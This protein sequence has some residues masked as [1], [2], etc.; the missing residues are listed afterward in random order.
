MVSHVREYSPLTKLL[1]LT[2]PPIHGPTRAA[3]M[4]PQPLDRAQETTKAYAQAVLE[5]GETESVPVLDVFAAVERAL[6]G[7][8]EQAAGLFRDGLHLNRDGYQVHLPLV[9]RDRSM[10]DLCTSSRWQILY[11][12]FENVVRAEFP[13]LDKDALAP[14]YPLWADIDRTD[15][16]K[17]VVPRPRDEL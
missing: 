2:P 3:L 6:G 8:L 5:V 14:V 11:D 7:D 15:I 4:A 13:E 9:S 12:A 1:L 16:A 10:T 17:S